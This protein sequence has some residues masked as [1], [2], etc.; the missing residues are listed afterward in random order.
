MLNIGL[1]RSPGNKWITGVCSG[2]ADYL[3]VNPMWVRLAVILIAIVPAGLGL[4]PVAIIYIALTI[5][6]PER[7]NDVARM[8]PPTF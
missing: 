1:Y 7:P 2:I 6:L 5:L 3:K 8:D 4:L